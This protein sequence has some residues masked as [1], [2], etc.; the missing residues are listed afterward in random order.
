MT[1]QLRA[2]LAFYTETAGR[3]QMRPAVSIIQ[4][5][6]SADKFLHPV[7]VQPLMPLIMVGMLDFSIKLIGGQQA[8]TALVARMDAAPALAL[9]IETVNWWNREAERVAL[10]Q[11]AFREGRH[12]RV[13]L[14]DALAGF[15]LEPLRPTLELST[16][17]KAIHNAAYDAVRLSRHYSIRP[18][19]IHDTM[20]TARRS[21][22][23]RYSLRAQAEA[24]LGVQIDKSEQRGDWG[25]RPLT[26][27]Q[28]RYA[29]LDA[30]CTLLLYEDQL[31]RGLASSYQPRDSNQLIQTSLPLS[32]A[33]Q[34]IPQAGEK[35]KVVDTE[36]NATE[37]MQAPAIALLGVV[38]ELA[39]R[40]SPDRLAV[41]A[42]SERVGLAG[43]II[44]QALGA[45][46][47]IDE[48]TAKLEL[49]ELCERGLV[50]LTA[51]RRLET[52]EAGARLWH[53]LKDGLNLR[54]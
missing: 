33:S 7:E 14:I 6:F 11:L 1:G 46:T 29:A 40:Y 12:L 51:A 32:E 9:D 42:G 16:M 23:K 38:A 19:P 50:R 43:W 39:G 18:A 30:A 49:A 31:G 10:I 15:E 45:E 21:G 8:L 35:A 22:E 2:V 52:T 25:R 44:D 4:T 5:G 26:T 36:A 37:E 53:Q 24:H 17:T 28:L 13:A 20:L 47:E 34:S 54:F 41:S 3:Y 48:E 27:K